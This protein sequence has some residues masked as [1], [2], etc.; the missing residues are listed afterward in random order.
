MG[1][2]AYLRRAS[3]VMPWHLWNQ[4]W[5][6]SPRTKALDQHSHRPRRAPSFQ[7]LPPESGLFE[8][9]LPPSRRAELAELKASD[10]MAI[11]TRSVDPNSDIVAELPPGTVIKPLATCVLE[12]GTKRL[13]ISLAGMDSVCVVAPDAL[14]N[15]TNR[16]S[17]TTQ[18]GWLTVLS[19]DGVLRVNKYARP[20]FEVTCHSLK[21]RRNASTD[22][23]YVRQLS[24]GTRLHITEL[25]RV[26]G[27]VRAHVVVLGLPKPLVEAPLGWITVR[28]ARYHPNVVE[29]LEDGQHKQG[30]SRL[31]ISLPPDSPSLKVTPTNPIVPSPESDRSLLTAR[32]GADRQG[33]SSLVVLVISPTRPIIRGGFYSSSSSSLP[34]QGVL[35]TG[36]SGERTSSSHSPTAQRPSDKTGWTSG[37]RSAPSLISQL[38][39]SR[40]SKVAGGTDGSADSSE[41]KGGQL[42]KLIPSAALKLECDQLQKER[43]NEAKRNRRRQEDLK[44][45]VSR[46][47]EASAADDDAKSPLSVALGQVI[48]TMMQQDSNL[49]VIDNLVRHFDVNRDG[50]TSKMEFRASVRK[51]L[52]NAQVPDIDILFKTLDRDLSGFLD[53]AEIKAMLKDLSADVKGAQKE[54]KQGDQVI[55]AIS[56]KIDR[57]QRVI[58][59]TAAYESAVAAKAELE[60]TSVGARLGTLLKA[61]NLMGLHG[62][63]LVESWGER[64][65]LISKQEFMKEALNILKK[66]VVADDPEDLVALFDLLDSNHN[67]SLDAAE[68][69]QGL[70]NLMQMRGDLYEEMKRRTAEVQ[71][72]KTTALRY[73]REW[74]EEKVAEEQAAQVRRTRAALDAEADREA[75]A[76]A[77][78][79]RVRK[80]AQKNEIDVISRQEFEARV[81]D[82]RKKHQEEAAKLYALQ[83]KPRVRPPSP[84]PRNRT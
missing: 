70:T 58:N 52:P 55:V 8:V 75:A 17:L 12:D 22:S 43:D 68:V 41:T 46:V 51:L 71:S 20:I 33:S 69:K 38:R 3:R 80:E 54:A 35:K 9:A 1:G 53:V 73:Q 15:A 31:R 59:A 21:M 6:P 11:V 74:A 26:D 72:K 83:H 77:M 65:G 19:S 49:T 64:S 36:T 18:A 66:D 81:E 10:A 27:A 24:Q 5:T 7:P 16:E 45:G 57:L 84:V 61:D 76:R 4:E 39:A 78:A 79:A 82:K 47:Q 40:N 29:L 42:N 67:G 50:R 28:S 48:A 25:K 32:Q 2:T 34:A 14:G 44:D 62:H 23:E 37:S 60:K 56:A 63:T 13:Y 30:A